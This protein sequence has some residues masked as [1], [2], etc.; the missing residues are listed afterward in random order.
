[1]VYAG[2]NWYNCRQAISRHKKEGNRLKKIIFLAFA[3]MM[4]ASVTSADE[5]VNGYQ[6]HDGTYVQGYHRSDPDGNKDNNYSHH[7]NT[8]PWTGEPGYEN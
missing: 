3:M 8:N 5:W 4:F 6:K 7:G 2:N 1:V